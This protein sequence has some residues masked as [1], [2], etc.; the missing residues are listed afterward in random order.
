[1][2]GDDR[3]WLSRGRGVMLLLALIG[4]GYLFMQTRRLP[5]EISGWRGAPVGGLAG[6]TLPAE[7][8]LQA[9]TLAIVGESVQLSERDRPP[10]D[11]APSGNP[12]G[13]P[14]TVMTQG[15]GVGSHAPAAVWGGVDLAIDGNGDGA[16]DPDGTWEAPI[17]A[18]QAG[19]AHLHPDSW[20]GGNYLAIESEHFKIAFAH[21]KAYAVQD[22][23]QVERGQVIGYVGSTG[24][25]SGPHLHYEIW[26]DG[27]NVNPLD[28]G[29]L[30]GTQ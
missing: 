21:L 10:D 14:N 5:T 22:G 7:P 18:T 29:A 26:Q 3:L 6:G 16:G 1:M 2:I 24:Q 13:V 23:Q 25:S 8:Q 27:I 11:G 15:Y 28:F 12:L 9:H 19:I 30:D 20:P 4:L 17:Y